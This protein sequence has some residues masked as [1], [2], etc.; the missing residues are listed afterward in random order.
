MQCLPV[1]L[2][3]FTFFIYRFAARPYIFKKGDPVKE[4][5]T[6]EIQVSILIPI[7]QVRG[8]F[9][10]Q[11]NGLS[12]GQDFP[13]FAIVRVFIASL[14]DDKVDVAVQGTVCP[15]PFSI[16]CIVP[17]IVTPVADPDKQVKDAV[18][19]LISI[20]PLVGPSTVE[21]LFVG[22]FDGFVV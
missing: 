18:A 2:Q 19:V 9:A 6:Y 4:F 1:K 7:N 20:F 21:F 17:A 16:I 15:V 11:I 10:I 8:W 5:T 12:F 14:V 22:N 13:G 3:K